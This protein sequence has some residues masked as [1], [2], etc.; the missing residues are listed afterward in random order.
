MKFK[1][2]LKTIFCKKCN[3]KTY[4][5]KRNNQITLLPCKCKDF[6]SKDNL[7]KLLWENI[8]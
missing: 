6:N 7:L 8:K 1:S 3:I 4:L 5:V 2:I